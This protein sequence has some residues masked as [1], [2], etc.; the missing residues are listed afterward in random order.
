[1]E[2]PGGLQFTGSP[3]SGHDW[4]TKQQ[5]VKYFFHRKTK[6]PNNQSPKYYQSIILKAVQKSL[7]E[8]QLSMHMQ[9]Q[10]RDWKRDGAEGT[11][12]EQ[13]QQKWV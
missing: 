4:A 10:G 1:M 3:N 5:L 2:E 6:K 8:Q 12:R 11:S 7:M 13:G 9:R